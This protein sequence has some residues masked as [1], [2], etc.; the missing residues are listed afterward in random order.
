MDAT[1]G[2]VAEGSRFQSVGV[3]EINRAG[4]IMD[5]GLITIWTGRTTHL[6]S[7]DPGRALITRDSAN[8]SSRCTGPAFS[9]WNAFKIPTLWGVR[10]TAPYFHDNSAK[11][12]GDVGAHYAQFFLD[13]SG[14]GRADRAGSGRCRRGI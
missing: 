10:N 14:S 2:L 11:T 12:L 7:P 13:D 1:G 5:F 9:D 4:Q 8:S 6:C 3:S